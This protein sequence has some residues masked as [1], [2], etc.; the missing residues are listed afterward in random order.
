MK[1]NIASIIFIIFSLCL[2]NDAY[3]KNKYGK[4]GKYG[5][6]NVI[7]KHGEPVINVQDLISDMVRKEEEIVKLTKNKKSLRKINVALATALSVVSAILL[8]GAGLVMYNTEKGRRPFQ[9]GKS[10]KG[11][12]AMARDSSF[13]MNEESPLGFSPEEMEA[14]ASKFRESMLKD[15]VPAPSNTPNV[16]N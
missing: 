12:S 6:Q 3:G 1:I 14:V 5:S 13:P 9:I 2:V 10:K 11:G 16:Q 15:G 7:K 4:N 8:G